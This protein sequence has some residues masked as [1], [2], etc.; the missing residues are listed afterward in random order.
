MANES[1]HRYVNR[2]VYSMCM[3]RLPVQMTLCAY[4]RKLVGA[5]GEIEH[6]SGHSWRRAS[7]DG[8]AHEM[9]DRVNDIDELFLGHRLPRHLCHSRCGRM[10]SFKALAGALQRIIARRHIKPFESKFLQP[11]RGQAHVAYSLPAKRK[12][13]GTP[14]NSDSSTCAVVITYEDAARSAASSHRIPQAIVV[15]TP[16]LRVLQCIVGLSPYASDRGSVGIAETALRTKDMPSS[17]IFHGK[18]CLQD[19]SDHM[20]TQRDIRV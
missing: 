11:I 18:R 9:P 5:A 13:N 12:I 4:Q 10:H 20:S 14:G 19:W 15:V 8:G 2:T 3:A 16:T 17:Q 6:V 7:S 1:W